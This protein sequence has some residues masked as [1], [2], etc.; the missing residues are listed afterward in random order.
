MKLKRYFI[1][2]ELNENYIVNLE[3]EEFHHLKN[4]MRTRVGD[5]VELFNG[6]TINAEAT[7]KSIDKNSASLYIEKVETNQSEPKINFTLFQAVCK[8]EK[9]SLITQKIT[10][11]GA[12]NLCVF[13]SQFTDIKDKT[14]KLDKLDRVCISACKQCGRSSTLNINGVIAFSDMINEAKKLDK[15]YVAYENADGITLYDSLIKNAN[16]KNIGLIIGAEGGFSKEEI[17]I[18]KENNFEIVSLG[19]RILRTET[20]AIAGSSTIIFACEK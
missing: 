12:S 9:L 8:G 7:I 4:V 14:S 1:E 13:Y 10:E 11:L 6:T 2:C 18:L 5:K 3:G 19:K 17:K 16:F 20:A 15:V